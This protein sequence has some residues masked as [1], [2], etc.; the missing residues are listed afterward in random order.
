M[1][2]DH[3]EK[4]FFKTIKSLDIKRNVDMSLGMIPKI[5]TNNHTTKTRRNEKKA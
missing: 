1:E 4:A 5:A 2:M 3:R